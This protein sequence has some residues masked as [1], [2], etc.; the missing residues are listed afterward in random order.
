MSQLSLQYSPWL[1]AVCLLVALGYS[2]LLYQT[3]RPW[4][5]VLNGLL[6]GLRFVAV[7]VICFLLL[8][9]FFNQVKNKVEKPTMVVVVDDSESMVLSKDSA[10]VRAFGAQLESFVSK[11]ENQGFSVEKKTL[12]GSIQ[13]FDSLSFQ[14]QSSNLS[15]ILRETGESFDQRNLGGLVLVSDGIFNQGMSPAFAT[16]NYPVYTLGVGDS[17]EQKDV[18]L[19]SLRHN[20]V[21]F[22]GNTF[23]IVAEVSHVGFGG[24]ELEAKLFE[25]GKLL[26]NNRLVLN[27]AR[28]VEQ[29]R[30]M[31]EAKEKGIFRYEVALTPLEGEMTEG[32]NKRGAYVKVVESKEQVLLVAPAPHPDIKAIRSIVERTD[33]YELVV[34]LLSAP[35]KLPEEKYGLVIFHQLPATRGR[36]KEIV[37]KYLNGKTSVLFMVGSQ[38][39]LN[40]LEQMDVPLQIDQRLSQTDEVLPAFNANFDKFIMDKEALKVFE[41]APPVKVPFGDYHLKGNAEVLAYQQL[42]SVTTKKPLMAFSEIRG[43]KVGVIVGEGFWRWRMFEFMEKGDARGFDG[44]MTK[45][46]QLVA[47]RSDQRHLIAEPSTQEFWDYQPVGFRLKTLND[48]FEPVYNVEVKV[49]IKDAKGN[50]Q[51]FS[52]VTAQGADVYKLKSLAEGAYTFVATATIAGK[53]YVDK[54]SFVISASNLEEMDLTAN[55]RLLRALAKQTGG[56]F[57]SVNDYEAFDKRFEAM[58][59][60]GVIHSTE[61]RME[62]IHLRWIFFFLLLL[63]TMEWAMRK[64]N[65]GY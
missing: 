33:R 30:F 34:Q 60:Q 26:T 31:V 8:G 6:A 52:M 43:K 27:G 1:V 41:V 50:V 16:Y 55:H 40:A 17:I 48:I 58:K 59:P 54:G 38:S 2:Y 49:A 57:E 9:P 32:N 61:A 45:Y 20:K 42:G 25:N 11:L 39:D 62:L 23:P 53:K 51:Q 46:L 10:R 15:A 28:G 44:L 35:K 37:Q 36:G 63:A 64:A 21:A 29:I 47:S 18:N 19:K 7:F 22:V 13:D 3:K 14:S 12:D 65:G 24:K 4:G 56:F 5:K